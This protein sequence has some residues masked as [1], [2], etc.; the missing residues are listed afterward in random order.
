MYKSIIFCIF[1]IFFVLLS[2]NTEASELVPYKKHAVYG[3]WEN[4]KISFI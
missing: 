3:M 2:A 4:D 1:N